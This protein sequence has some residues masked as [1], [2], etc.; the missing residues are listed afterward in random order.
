MKIRDPKDSMPLLNEMENFEMEQRKQQ[1]PEE[2]KNL[3]SG[4]RNE[5]T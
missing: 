5:K 4:M 1:V 2:L 3:R